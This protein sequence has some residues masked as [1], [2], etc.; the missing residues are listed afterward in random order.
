LDGDR[1]LAEVVHGLVEVIDG[2]G[3]PLQVAEQFAN[4]KRFFSPRPIATISSAPL[5][6]QY[7]ES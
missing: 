4:A 2:P 7:M 5:P 6:N 1:P 3:H